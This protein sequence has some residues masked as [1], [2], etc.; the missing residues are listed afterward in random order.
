VGIG[1]LAQRS[2]IFLFRMITT[3]TIRSETTIPTADRIP[4]EKDV[5]SPFLRDNGSMAA[6]V[7]I[8]SLYGHITCGYI[9]IANVVFVMFT[10][11]PCKIAL[12]SSNLELLA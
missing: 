5:S 2:L 9:S 10:D 8:Q 7:M 4:F 1:N 12:E 6:A 11:L 3:I